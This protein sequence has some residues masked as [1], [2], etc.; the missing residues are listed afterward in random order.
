MFELTYRCNFSCK[1]CYVPHSYRKKGELS[2][3]QIFSVLDQLVEIGCFYLGFTGGEPFIRD[4]IIDILWYAK[5]KGFQI[6]IYTNGSLINEVIA[7]ELKQLQPNKVD[8]TIPA[9]D[10]TSFGSITGT[11]SFRDRVFTAISLLYKNGVNLGFKTCVLKG[12]ESQ[13]KT[14]QDFTA[15]LGVQH[16]LAKGLSRCLD[17]STQPYLYR[18]ALKNNLEN[19][20]DLQVP[21]IGNQVLVM[22]NQNQSPKSLQLMPDTLFKCGVGISQAAITPLGELK[23]CLMIDRPKYKILNITNKGQGASLE[24]A[25][26][27][28]KQFAASIKPDGNYQ[29]DECEIKPYCKWCPARAWLYNNSFTSCD[30]QIRHWAVDRKQRAERLTILS[31]GHSY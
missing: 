4:D 6:I 25:W 16:R 31:Q 28:L 22:N 2:T 12:N 18:G 23:M 3:E 1:H 8:I 27:R 19:D 11:A 13:I 14:I 29:C 26:C 17:G 5:K 30:P 10:K 7:K 21:N 20:C 9:M 15:S 24:R